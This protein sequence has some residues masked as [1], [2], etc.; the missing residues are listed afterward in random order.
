MR[1]GETGH[2]AYS[3][4]PAYVIRYISTFD[5]A[6]EAVR[7]FHA[8]LFRWYYAVLGAGLL[9]GAL[10]ALTTLPLGLPIVFAC[11]MLLLMMR[12]AVAERLTGRRQARSVPHPPFGRWPGGGGGTR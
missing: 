1:D 5:E 8:R 4:P 6:I 12:F 7:F 11:G 3:A 10:I 2:A 9:V